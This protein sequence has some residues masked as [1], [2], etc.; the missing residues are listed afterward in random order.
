MRQQ[1]T[2]LHYTSTHLPSTVRRGGS[3]AIHRRSATGRRESQMKQTGVLLTMLEASWI[4]T[5]IKITILCA[6]KKVRIE[7]AWW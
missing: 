3:M 2:G 6:E 4:P 1:I 5:A 7:Q